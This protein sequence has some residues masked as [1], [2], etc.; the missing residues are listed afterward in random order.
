MADDIYPCGGECCRGAGNAGAC[1]TILGVGRDRHAGIRRSV[2]NALDDA[3][4]GGSNDLERVFKLPRGSL[5]GM[6][7]DW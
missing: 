2:G 6:T 1:F 5:A 7:L 3:A 4:G